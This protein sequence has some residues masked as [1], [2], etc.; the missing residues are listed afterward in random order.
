MLERGEGG[1]A[2]P[3]AALEL[4]V[5]A[6]R[7]GHA[8]ALERLLGMAAEGDTAVR[9]RLG[10]MYLHGDGVPSDPH[11][12]RRWLAAAAEP[13][14]ARAWLALGWLNQREGGDASAAA[15]E[16]YERAAAI[17]R[18]LGDPRR[19]RMLS[20]LK[21]SEYCVS[22]L[23]QLLDEPMPA[24]SQRLRL[25]KSERIVRSRRVGKRVYYALADEHI[26]QLVSNALLH[27]LE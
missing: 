6:A 13:G 21:R 12:S 9:F 16:A 4:F 18:A 1:D 24:I 2:D 23:S 7:Q 14:D 22:D 5:A 8:D 25:L 11:V 27:A 19:L 26:F 10:L 17:F 20:L 15:V 3:Q